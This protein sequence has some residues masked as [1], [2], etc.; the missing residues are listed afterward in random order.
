M[1]FGNPSQHSIDLIKN[2]QLLREWEL[3]GIFGALKQYPYPCEMTT[4]LEIEYL[5]SVVNGMDS[6]RAAYV[7][8]LDEDLFGVMSEYLGSYGVTATAEEIKGLVD[9][10]EPIID[11]L[12]IFYNRPR[13]F[14][15]AG[16]VGLPL[17]PRV[18]HYSTESSYPSGHT[19]FALFFYHIY[20]TR[21]PHLKQDLMKFVMDVKLSREQAGV[22]YPS[23]NLFSFQVY[24]H[25][26]PYMNIYD[27][28]A[29]PN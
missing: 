17:Y 3:R 15:V 12:K 13:P 21:H 28:F 9:P 4:R 5:I 24:R 2:S 10:Y 22:H 7:Q 8:R 11:Y 20:G 26:Q 18:K 25:L 6:T 1:I 19:L 16:V 14:Q 27:T 23:D 29:R